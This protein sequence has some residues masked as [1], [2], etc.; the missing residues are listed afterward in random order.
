MASPTTARP[1]GGASDVADPRR[2][3]AP[4]VGG[5]CPYLLAERGRW[6]SARPSRDH[7][8]TAV[9]SPLP[10]AA[11][12]QLELCLVDR[13]PTCPRFIA[14]RTQLEDAG[15]GRVHSTWAF[16]APVPVLLEGPGLHLDLPRTVRGRPVGQVLLGLLMILAFAAVVLARGSAPA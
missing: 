8:C 1:H 12:K 13:H 7:R 3:S 14:A 10:V 5:I 9:T 6:R 2:G 4:D 16:G 11:D 15:V